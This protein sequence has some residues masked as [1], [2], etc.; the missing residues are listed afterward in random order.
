MQ[1][2]I[3]RY[4][5][6]DAEADVTPV[7]GQHGCAPNAACKGSAPEMVKLIIEEGTETDVKDGMGRVAIHFAAARS[8]RNLQLILIAGA[9]IEVKDRMGRTAIH[10]AV[11]GGQID[12]VER[13]LAL[14]RGLVDQADID[15]WTPLLWAAKGCGTYVKPATSW[16]QEK[17]ITLLLDRGAD[18]CIRGKGI[19]SRV[20]TCESCEVP[21]G[22]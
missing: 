14:S 5:V 4:L 6:N 1:E 3:I 15:G 17:I 16:T 2:S 12:V 22:R 13:V 21:W 11:I 8:P 20:V 9:D 10:W 19:R 7:G 18:P